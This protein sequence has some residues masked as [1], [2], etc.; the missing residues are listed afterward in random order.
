MDPFADIEPFLA[1][2]KIA[3]LH[4][5]EKKINGFQDRDEIRWIEIKLEFFFNKHSDP[6]VFPGRILCDYSSRLAIE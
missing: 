1:D 6:R 4:M 2:K 3:I 5:A